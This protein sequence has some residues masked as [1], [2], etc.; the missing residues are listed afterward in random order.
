MIERYAPQ[1]SRKLMVKNKPQRLVMKQLLGNIIKAITLEEGG[2]KPDYNEVESQHGRR[3]NIKCK[4]FFS[5]RVM[6][7]G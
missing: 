5:S 6:V 7:K 2:H 3:K 1:K 4:T